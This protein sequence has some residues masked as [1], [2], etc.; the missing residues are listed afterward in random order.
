MITYEAM[1][2]SFLD[3]AIEDEMK[4][5][6]EKINKQTFIIKPTFLLLFFCCL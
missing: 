5:N 4:K 1:K 3:D 2:K 6:I